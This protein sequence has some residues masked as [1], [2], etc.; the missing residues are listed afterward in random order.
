MTVLDMP[1]VEMIGLR[2]AQQLFRS[3]PVAVLR[4]ARAGRLRMIEVRE[5]GRVRTLFPL[6]D[7]E[8]LARERTISRTG[9]E[10]R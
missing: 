2:R 4:E 6:A 9:V 5:G 10:A 3:G 7:V 8:R 1:G